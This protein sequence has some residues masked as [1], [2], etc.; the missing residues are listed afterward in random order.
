MLYVSN[1]SIRTHHLTRLQWSVENDGNRAIANLIMPSLTS[2]PGLCLSKSHSQE[3]QRWTDR[4]DGRWMPFSSR[5]RVKDGEIM[6][7]RCIRWRCKSVS[8]SI[9][10]APRS[11]SRTS[12][13]VGGYVGILRRTPFP[14]KDEGQ[15]KV[16]GTS[17]WGKMKKKKKDLFRKRRKKTEEARERRGHRVKHNI[18]L[19]L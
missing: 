10:R 8:K 2:P 4:V 16:P 5:E 7:R 12:A 1:L 9:H 11:D 18:F 15:T 13:G 14:A 17:L 19:T 3:G 6:W